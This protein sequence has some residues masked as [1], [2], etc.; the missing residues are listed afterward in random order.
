MSRDTRP[1]VYYRTDDGEAVVNAALD[2]LGCKSDKERSQAR[3]ALLHAAASSL[4]RAGIR[5]PAW[6]PTNAGLHI[7]L[8]SL[9]GERPP[10]PSLD[11]LPDS[12]EVPADL[13]A[14]LPAPPR[15][16][17]RHKPSVW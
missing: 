5:Y 13:T 9:S 2:L 15:E 3:G 10:P 1:S 14:D 16:A 12:S 8:S 11:D 6:Q 7:G 4:V 17:S